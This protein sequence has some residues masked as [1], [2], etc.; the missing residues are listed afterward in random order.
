M[1]GLGFLSKDNAPTED[2]KKALP[3]D[4]PAPTGNVDRIHK[5][6]E[7]TKILFNNYVF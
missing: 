2:A 4:I 1:V 5:I 3:A 6:K 7:L